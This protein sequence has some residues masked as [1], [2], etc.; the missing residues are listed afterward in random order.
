MPDRD[1][2]DPPEITRDPGVWAA[3]ACAGLLTLGFV[4]FSVSDGDVGAI[5]TSTFEAVNELPDSLFPGMYLL[6]IVGV[7][8][9]GPLVAVAAYALGRRR[10]AMAAMLAT[11]AKLI[12]ERL[13]KLVVERER[14]YSSIGPTVETRGDVPES[15]L[16]YASGHAILTVALATIAS[17]YL[18]ARWR[19][20]PW[21]LVV[22][23]GVARV[24][25]GAHNPLDMIGGFGLGLAIGGSLNLA[26][27]TPKAP[28]RH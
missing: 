8:A 18:P 1:L 26:L 19:W 25:V 3:V 23:N 17:P 14:P 15:G 7:I 27:G 12:S 22:G 20:V 5:E 6:Q 9:I 10:L 24:Y 4:S 2:S 11:V 13:L 28:P 21:A 16:S